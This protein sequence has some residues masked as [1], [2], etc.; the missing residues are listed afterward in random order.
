MMFQPE[1]IQTLEQ[2]GLTYLQAKVYLTLVKTG[3]NK[4]RN[5]AEKAGIARQEAQRVTTEL[6]NIGLVEKIVV[7]PA[8]FDPVPL[9]EAVKFLVERR[10]KASL[11]IEKKV[12]ALLMNLSENRLENPDTEKM[13]KFAMIS[14]KEAIIRRQRMMAE[15]TKESSD[16]IIGLWKN[17]RYESSLFA[18]AGN[19]AL[20][21]RVKIRILTGKLTEEQIGRIFKSD[22]ENP[23][24]E[25]KFLSGELPVTLGIYDRKELLVFTF[26]EKL[27]N[28]DSS[29]LWTNDQ[30]LID[31]VQTYFDKLW[32][33]AT[34]V[35]NHFLAEQTDRASA[36]ACA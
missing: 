14:G 32:K 24:F 27:I 11:E 36:N 15:R 12:K 29:M 20:R 19:R 35:S 31:A 9:D 21:R 33:E 26:P 23:N 5:I 1:D 22:L 8:E 3:K 10:E 2:L 7:S 28:G 18:E 17:L 25:T 6:Q 30:T 4:V 34:P 16:I 13:A